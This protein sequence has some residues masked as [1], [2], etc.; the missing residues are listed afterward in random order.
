MF[1][2]NVRSNLKL[3]RYF[4]D[5]ESESVSLVL[6]CLV[7]PLQL[8]VLQFLGHRQLQLLFLR[9]SLARCRH[10]YQNIDHHFEVHHTQR[11]AGL[12]RFQLVFHVKP[13]CS[14]FLLRFKL[15][16][17]IMLMSVIVYGYTVVAFNF[18]RKFYSKEEDG[19]MEHNC[20]DLFTVNPPSDCVALNSTSR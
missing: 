15:L 16:L 5:S 3:D 10:Q 13:Y 4:Q 8:L 17:T 2:D 18:F 20:Q 12:S 6:S 1:T 14:H 9:V 11:Q 19:E 7:F